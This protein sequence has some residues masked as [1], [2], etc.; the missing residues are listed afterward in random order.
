LLQTSEH[1]VTDS[2]SA[3]HVEH[4]WRGSLL[5]L[6]V[7]LAIMGPLPLSNSSNSAGIEALEFIDFFFTYVIYKAY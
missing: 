1:L 5:T 6:P 7:C 2:D 4:F 3:V